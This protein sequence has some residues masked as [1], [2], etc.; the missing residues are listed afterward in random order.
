MTLFLLTAAALAALALLPASRLLGRSPQA[1]RGRREAALAL[2]RAQLRE[3]DRDARL[4]L[5]AQG[6]HGGA[7]LEIERRLLA[8]SD[9]SDRD[10]RT[11][12][13]GRV[14]LAAALLA[15]PVLAGALYAIGGHPRMGAD[16]LGPRRAADHARNARADA[17]I[18]QIRA[19][20]AGLDPHSD[21]AHGGNILLGTVEARLGRWQ[22]AA[23]AWR[24]ALVSG[25]DPA[26][27]DE[28]AEAG[29]LAHGGR[30]DD[31]DATL[32]R[33]AL[34]QAPADAPWRLSAEARLAEREHQSLP[35]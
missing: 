34:A 1:A 5:V 19:G 29:I 4:G 35:P 7:R 23:D 24:A 27:A 14:T 28:A 17:L 8:A 9:Q 32:L 25:F 11:Q 3:L 31:A 21:Q 10:P 15:I 18:A 26:L 12:A 13:A 2:H 6:E 30:I 33:Q 22:P 16:P 20:L